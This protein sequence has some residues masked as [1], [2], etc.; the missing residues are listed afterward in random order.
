MDGGGGA[1]LPFGFRVCF[2]GKRPETGS[3]KV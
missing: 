3:F 2:G 1:T